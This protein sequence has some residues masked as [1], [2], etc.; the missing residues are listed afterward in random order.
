MITY[1]PICQLPMQYRP[2]DTL[3]YATFCCSATS[4]EW[5]DCGYQYEFGIVQVDKLN[6]Q[7]NILFNDTDHFHYHPG[8]YI[9][10][11]SFDLPYI[12]YQIPISFESVTEMMKWIMHFR[13][14]VK[15]YLLFL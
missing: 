9:E 6:S 3:Y 10:V 4:G 15:D 12:P 13:N 7:I 2:A 8:E 1:C 14:N 5:K 11:Y